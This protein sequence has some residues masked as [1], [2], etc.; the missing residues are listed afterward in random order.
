MR[1]KPEET[2]LAL[3]CVVLFGSMGMLVYPWLAHALFS[4]EGQAA[5]GDGPA[6]LLEFLGV[7]VDDVDVRFLCQE[8]DQVPILTGIPLQQRFR[9]DALGVPG[10]NWDVLREARRKLTALGRD[11]LAG[12][13]SRRGLR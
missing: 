6:A 13:I 9:D 8:R 5:V 3:T 7:E 4:G 12:V 10:E 11:R 1:A 2:G